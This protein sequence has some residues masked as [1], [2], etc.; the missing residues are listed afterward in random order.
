MTAAGEV[1]VLFYDREY[2]K[3]FISPLNKKLGI[4]KV[5]LQDNIKNINCRRHLPN[6][7]KTNN[8]KWK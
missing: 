8:I 3:E 7:I 4:H 6:E 1:V 2:R 5:N